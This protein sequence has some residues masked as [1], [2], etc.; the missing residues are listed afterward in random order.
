MRYHR[1]KFVSDAEEAHRRR[2]QH[3]VDG[4]IG[5]TAEPCALPKLFRP[6][7][8]A[9]LMLEG[10]NLHYL[11]CLA[12]GR[13]DLWMKAA[14]ATVNLLGSVPDIRVIRRDELEQE[15]KAEAARALADGQEVRQEK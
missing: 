13:L 7:N 10:L 1:Y 3:I 15:L 4:L 14:H 11:P 2:T 6:A 12:G 9:A 5:N 8:A